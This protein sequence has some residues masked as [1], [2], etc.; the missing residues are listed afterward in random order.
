MRI[1]PSRDLQAGRAGDWAFILTVAA[2]YLSA[3]VTPAVF[4]TPTILRLVAL[5]IVYVAVGTLGAR[6]VDR[7]RSIPLRLLYFLIEILLAMV[8]LFVGSIYGSFWVIT[9]PLVSQAVVAL[10]RGWM[11]FVAALVVLL[12]FTLPLGILAGWDKALQNTIFF[13]T[14]VVFVIIFTQIAVRERGLRG[15]VERLA[16]ELSEANSQLRR[17]AVQAEEL[18]TARERNRLA[19][20]IHDS[21]GHYLTVVNVQLEAAQA[22][23]STDPGRAL[24]PLQKAQRLTRD[25]L[26]DIRRSVAALRASPLEDRP[27]PEALERLVESCREAGLVSA[28][29]TRGE[30]RSL[31]PQVELTLFRA[32]QEALTNVRKHARASRCDVGLEY[33]PGGVCLSVEDNGVGVEDRGQGFGI[34]GVRERAQLLGGEVRIQTAM[35]RGFRLEVDIPG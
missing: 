7:T 1:S 32:A 11:I 5:G 9:L 35:G 8:I 3:I 17:Y 20:E 24:E 15:E 2:G 34:Q 13:V 14:G 27:L 6:L 33:R 4:D 28:L 21:L 29:V 18:A 23:L 30:P 22:L 12:G 19:R 10:P 31:P 25:G 26:A 16:A